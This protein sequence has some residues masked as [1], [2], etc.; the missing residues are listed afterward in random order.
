MSA[1]NPSSRNPLFINQSLNNHNEHD[2]EICKNTRI[3]QVAQQGHLQTSNTYVASIFDDQ[4]S[5]N[6]NTTCHVSNSTDKPSNKDELQQSSYNESDKSSIAMKKR[7]TPI[8]ASYSRRRA[9]IK[10]DSSKVNLLTP[11]NK[12]RL[13]GTTIKKPV[14]SAPIF[15]APKKM[16]HHQQHT[17]STLPF[18]ELHHPK[19]KYTLERQTATSDDH[20]NFSSMAHS[21]SHSSASSLDDEQFSDES[22]HESLLIRKKMSHIK[23]HQLN[24]SAPSCFNFLPTIF[25]TDPH[26][27]SHT[28]DVDHDLSERHDS[29]DQT[30]DTDFNSAISNNSMDLSSLSDILI[31]PSS[32][33]E[34]HRLH[35]IGEEEEDEDNH[36][37]V[38][39][40]SKELERIEASK[41]SH[42]LNSDVQN[43]DREETDDKEPLGRRWS[44]GIVDQDKQ[45][46]SL[47]KTS[48]MKMPSA[49]S[50]TTKHTDTP[51][52]KLSKTKYILMKLRLTSSS[53]DDESD[54]SPIS[55]TI[56]TIV[57]NPPKKRTVHRSSDKK[58]YQTR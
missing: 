49:A 28:F 42:Q 10:T 31:S 5:S 20:P 16:S 2:N 40:L 12:N 37:N 23:D 35:S 18:D 46:A 38:N 53:K 3:T 32:I 34:K 55:T 43:K 19:R 11:N 15:I 58:R 30:I 27:Y 6:N 57:T 22:D 41:R 48:L 14:K 39:I 56:T 25:I 36:V 1:L 52:V 54:M 21:Y 26:G 17:Y 44:D 8:P 9:N 51:P 24:K 45:Q 4:T 47:S 33:L 50:I 29:H 13:G 7:T